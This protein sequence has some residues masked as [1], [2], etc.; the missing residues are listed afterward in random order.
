ML[1]PTERRPVGSLSIAVVSPTRRVLQCAA[2][3]LQL[4]LTLGRRRHLTV[5]AWDGSHTREGIA[6][7]SAP[8]LRVT[9][10][11]AHAI[12]VAELD[13]V[14]EDPGTYIQSYAEVAAFVGYALESLPDA[15]VDDLAFRAE[16]EARL[17][18]LE[19]RCRPLC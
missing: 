11:P 9:V 19:A 18:A 6:E 1:N 8:S 12:D 10:A 17:H 16:V 7:V 15:D 4:D 5:A 3:G 2:P 14:D 13:P